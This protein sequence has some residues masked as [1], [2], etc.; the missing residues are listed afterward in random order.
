M[1]RSVGPDSVSGEPNEHADTG[2]V[3]AMAIHL[4]DVSSRPVVRDRYLRQ[5]SS[6][7]HGKF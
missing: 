6:S 1:H 5:I 7:K 2:G 3:R 4:P